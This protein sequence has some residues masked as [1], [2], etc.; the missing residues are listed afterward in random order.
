M[1]LPQEDITTAVN[2]WTSR[3]SFSTVNKSKGI[4]IAGA[5]IQETVIQ[6]SK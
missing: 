6:L 3:T 4:E 1:V 5:V 2:C